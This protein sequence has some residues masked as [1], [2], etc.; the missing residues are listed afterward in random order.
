QDIEIF[1]GLVGADKVGTGGPNDPVQVALARLCQLAAHEVG[2]TLGFAHNF[3]AS[4]QDRA[5]VMDYPPPRI[6]LVNGKPDL[7]D[8]YGVGLGKWDMATVDWLYGAQDNAAADAKA[9]AD[10]ASSMRYIEDAN[11]RA[12]DTAQR[13]AALWDDG[14]DPTAELIRIMTV[15][16]AA[17][18]NF[19]LAMLSPGEPIADLRRRFVAI[20]LLH[21]YEV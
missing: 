3:A 7:S 21:R 13:W 14:P 1:K 16:S 10:V 4:T 6:G 2:H 20:W 17:I 15:R 8:A 19:G 11:A 9:S 12:P 18:A 5:S